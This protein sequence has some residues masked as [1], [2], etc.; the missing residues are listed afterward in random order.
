[1]G[2][3]YEELLKD[4]Y[5]DQEPTGLRDAWDTWIRKEV[6]KQLASFLKINEKEIR[7][8][9]EEDDSLDEALYTVAKE[10]GEIVRDDDD[11]TYYIRTEDIDW[12]DFTQRLL[13]VAQ[14]ECSEESVLLL[15]I[16]A[17]KAGVDVNVIMVSKT[18]YV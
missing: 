7:K 2:G 1:M 8:L 13:K 18:F 16:W 14:V 9:L 15:T 3:D 17:V 5:M 12:K 4:I 10:L 6:L 11:E